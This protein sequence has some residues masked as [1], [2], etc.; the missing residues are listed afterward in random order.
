M[1][2]SF[3]CETCRGSIRVADGSEGELTRC[4]ECFSI[5][6]VP[7]EK[8]KTTKQAKQTAPADDP[9][10]IEGDIQSRWDEVYPDAQP[11]EEPEP[12]AN[13]FTYEPPQPL[14]EKPTELPERETLTPEQVA[15]KLTQLALATSVLLL[16]STLSTLCI[17]ALLGFWV[18]MVVSTSSYRFTPIL[19]GVLIAVIL[20]MHLVTL[21]FLFEARFRRDYSRS[22]IGTSLSLIPLLNLAAVLSFPYSFWGLILL[23]KPQ[24]RMHFRGEG[25]ELDYLYQEQFER[26]RQRLVFVANLLFMGCC[27][28]AVLL[29]MATWILASAMIANGVQGKYELL[30]LVAMTLMTFLHLGTIFG[31]H[32][33]RSF[34]NR[35]WGLT[36]MILSIIPICN[37]PGILLF[38]LS[39]WGILLLMT[40]KMRTQFR[41]HWDRMTE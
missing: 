19:L 38:P 36:G 9:L 25:D 8:R 18:Y 34:G 28:F 13:P 20:A 31:L 30:T 41:S 40:P 15:Q 22:V 11:I 12:S 17:A 32:E 10:G 6:P 5:V 3:H 39:I 2:I 24:V 21:R 35:R 14:P 26:R 16:A 1:P 29:T 27:L 37:I 7:F 4:P 23:A 33:A